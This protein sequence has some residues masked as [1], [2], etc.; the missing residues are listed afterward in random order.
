MYKD[1]SKSSSTPKAV[2][3]FHDFPTN[4]LRPYGLEDEKPDE[5]KALRRITPL[6]CEWLK[7]L[8]VATSEF[9]DTLD[10]NFQFLCSSVSQFVKNAPFFKMQESMESFLNALRKFNTLKSEAY[11]TP[12]DVKTV[13]KGLL[14]DNQD[15]DDFFFTMFH[16][17]GAMYLLGSHYYV[18]KN[19][20]ANPEWL[21]ET[22]F[23]TAL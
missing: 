8:K 6:N 18:V 9:T 5:Q 13:M 1:S 4:F 20:M 3:Y 21:A 23:N 10:A 15:Q 12:A 11:P 2:N 14:E 22:V 16:L 19:L 7:H 17:G